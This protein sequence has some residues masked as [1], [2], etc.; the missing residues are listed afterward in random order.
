M[1]IHGRSKPLLALLN[2]G[3]T[4]QSNTNLKLCAYNIYMVQSAAHFSIT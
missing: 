4:L 1:D 2:L 3:K